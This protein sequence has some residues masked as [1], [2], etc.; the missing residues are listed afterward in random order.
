VIDHRLGCPAK[1]GLYAIAGETCACGADQANAIARRIKNAAKWQR[2]RSQHE[3]LLADV[4]SGVAGVAAYHREASER[5]LDTAELLEEATA[6]P[7]E[8]TTDDIIAMPRSV[9]RN[10]LLRMSVA[11][12]FL[13]TRRVMPVPEIAEWDALV[14]RLAEL[15]EDH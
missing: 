11:R 14:V 10:T 13:N 12:E 2:T 1:A 7:S 3:A 15:Q 4:W 5:H 6:V 8:P 9:L